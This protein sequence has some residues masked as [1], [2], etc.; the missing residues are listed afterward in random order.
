MDFDIRVIYSIPSAESITTD[1]L[2]AIKIIN[3]QS[4]MFDSYGN[5]TLYSDQFTSI[6][7]EI[8]VFLGDQL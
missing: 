2:E 4:D 1:P 7:K 8:G 5:C 6:K 3:S